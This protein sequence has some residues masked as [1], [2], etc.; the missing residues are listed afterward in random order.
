MTRS[1]KFWP[2]CLSTMQAVPDSLSLFRQCINSLLQLSVLTRLHHK[3]TFLNQ[4]F[5]GVIYFWM[6]YLPHLQ[7]N[8]QDNP[9]HPLQQPQ[10]QA[11]GQQ[12]QEVSNSGWEERFWR[13]RTLICLYYS[14][15]TH[16]SPIVLAVGPS[17][18]VNNHC[19]PWAFLENQV[20]SNVLKQ[21]QK[22]FFKSKLT[23]CC[24]LVKGR[25]SQNNFILS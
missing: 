24:Y 17:S 23:N 12:L 15:T 5:L 11:L 6:L 9:N 25:V 18:G 1:W 4:D 8:H 19:R 7:P 14:Q 20:E 21:A 22:V 3:K 13:R 2:V 16:L 10:S